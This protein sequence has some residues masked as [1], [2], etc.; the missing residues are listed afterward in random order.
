MAGITELQPGGWRF[1][2]MKNLG[3]M[4][5]YATHDDFWLSQ[6]RRAIRSKCVKRD[7]VGLPSPSNLGRRE[8]PSHIRSEE[9]RDLNARR[10]EGS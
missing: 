1:S 6:L 10:E 8:S 2:R 4:V 5:T 7:V 9:T 3:D